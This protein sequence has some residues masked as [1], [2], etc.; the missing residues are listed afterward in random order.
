MPDP[1][2]AQTIHSVLFR[3]EQDEQDVEWREPLF[4]M[5]VLILQSQ[6]EKIKDFPQ[7][8]FTGLFGNITVREGSPSVRIEAQIN[9]AQPTAEEKKG[10][11]PDFCLK[12]LIII[13]CV[14][15][16]V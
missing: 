9:E 7:L 11:T 5:E 3:E 8:S 15:F 6:W 2:R 10:V 12:Y 4:T 16:L 1:E 13:F 14:L